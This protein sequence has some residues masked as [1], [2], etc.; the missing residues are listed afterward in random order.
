MSTC[1]HTRTGTHTHL[2]I[3]RRGEEEKE[4]MNLTPHETPQ[5][6][7]LKLGILAKKKILRE[8]GEDSMGVLIARVAISWSPEA[9]TSQG[10]SV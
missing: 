5:V 7:Y 2:Y 3:H 8:F 6:F 10:S 9:Q 1:T 4:R